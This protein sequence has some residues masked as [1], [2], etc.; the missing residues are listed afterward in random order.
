MQVRVGIFLC[1]CGES[2]KNIDFSKVKEGV[3]KFQDVVHVDLNR[4][5]C[6]KE[7]CEEMLSAIRERNINRVVVAACSPELKQNV[8]HKAIEEAG[9]NSNLLSMANIRE[10]CSWAH[11]GDVTGKALE[12]T[13]MSANKARFLQPVETGEVTV[14]NEVLVVGGGFSGMKS[15][16]E[17]T[18][19]NLRV[20]LVERESALGG[21]LLESE[22]FYGIEITPE[23]MLGSMREAIEAD[24]NIEVLTPAEV[25]GVE[26]KA[27]D[28]R[29]ELRRNGEKLLRSFGAI[30]L[31]SGYQTEVW[32]ELE[33]ENIICSVG[34]LKLLQQREKL[35][36]T[37]AFVLDVSDEHSRL[38]TLSTLNNAL[39]ARERLG[40]EVYVFVRNLK[41]DSEGAEKLYRKAREKG[42]VFLKFEESPRYFREDARLRIEVKDVLLG[43]EVTLY[44]DIV[45]MEEKALPS[46]ELASML[47]VGTDAR[48]FYQEVNPHL[49]PVLSSCKG[50][51]F[52][53]SCRADMD[54][55][56]ASMDAVNAAFKVY[57]FLC[58][59]RI[60]VEV[61]R[62]KV[63]A[64]KCR[65]CLTCLRVCPH[66]AIQVEHISQ[67]P[68]KLFPNETARI[69]DLACDGC[70]I[71]AALCPAKAIGYE[72]YSDEQI[73][74]RIE[75][76]GAS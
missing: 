45:V 26:G 1:N 3:E 62:V 63:D 44:C 56:R 68:E 25:T 65:G 32:P 14:N 43:K 18:K 13:K 11:Q 64:D 59:G 22:S 46:A 53:G 34:L 12:L 38:S 8:F 5:L 49:F 73:L 58:P 42:V 23:Q 57:E 47:N 35:P 54:L 10:Q 28:F 21:R 15:A 48:G 33:S 7:G 41:I 17:L 74:A 70:G 20:T 75:A 30:V 29:V 55:V 19:L 66:G 71:C 72:G 67:E 31:A 27:G 39:T 50:V 16:L 61:E 52:A 69:Y 76:I 9:L 37:L 6:L 51:F 60:Q 36:K 24:E 4:F 2:L 40:S